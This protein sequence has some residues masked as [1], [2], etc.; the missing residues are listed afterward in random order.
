M[1][2][3]TYPGRFGSGDLATAFGLAGREPD[4]PFLR[5]ML[6]EIDVTFSLTR[7]AGFPADG[8]TQARDAVTGRVGAYG[9]GEELWGNDLLA[10][11]ERIPGT[12][13]TAMSVLLDGADVS[14]EPAPL[15]GIWGVK[16]IDVTV[17]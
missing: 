2:A 17:K 14:G 7:R 4:G 13:V 12:R 5:P 9:V 11:V 6:R 1:T 15:N 8:L 16:K 10:A 3:Q